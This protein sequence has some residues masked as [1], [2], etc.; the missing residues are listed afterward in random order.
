MI[1]STLFH[2]VR[3]V[4][5]LAHVESADLAAMVLPELLRRWKIERQ[6]VVSYNLTPAPQVSA[7]VLGS[8]GIQKGLRYI[9]LGCPGSSEALR[10][11]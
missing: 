1:V 5:E 4:R 6:S 3:L 11:R 2:F 7:Q 10:E 9:L 8:P